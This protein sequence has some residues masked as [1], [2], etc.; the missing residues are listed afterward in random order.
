MSKLCYNCGVENNP[1][2]KKC[3]SCKKPLKEKKAV[4]KPL[5]LP[6]N[7]NLGKY[8]IR[9]LVT[10]TDMGA[11][12]LGENKDTGEILAIKELSPSRASS[13]EEKEYTV[14]KFVN[15]SVL[16]KQLNFISV[17]RVEEYFIANENHYMSMEF[18]EGLD[19]EGMVT[20]TGTPGLPQEQVVKWGMQICEVLDYLHKC[21]PQIIYR[22]LKPANIM[23]RNS[24]NSVVLIDFGIAFSFHEDLKGSPRTKIGT[25]GYMAPEQFHGK[26]SPA[27]DVF[28]LGATLYYALTGQVQQLFNYIPMTSI[29][30]EIS[31]ELDSIIRCSLQTSPAKR[32]ASAAEMKEALENLEK[33]KKKKEEELKKAIENLKPVESKVTKIQEVNP[34]IFTAIELRQEKDVDK[35]LDLMEK[36]AEFSDPVVG[37]TLITILLED[38]DLICCEEAAKILGRKKITEAIS[39]LIEVIDDEESDSDFVV[40]CIE[41]LGH[42][43]EEQSLK[44]LIKCLKSKDKV[45]RKSAASALKNT[46]SEKALKPLI[47]ARKKEGLFN[48]DVKKIIDSAIKSIKASSGIELPE[49]EDNENIFS[50]LMN[51]IK[52]LL[53]ARKKKKAKKTVATKKQ[54]NQIQ[55]KKKIKG[56]KARVKK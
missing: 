42:F 23:I 36:L 22:D 53:G 35:K 3:E 25:M 56:K 11:V 18:I 50:K 19:M 15:E 54:T 2:A 44:C 46:G 10:I 43:D 27:S 45:I 5:T 16:L 4:A 13:E 33:N 6:L 38:E 24:D 28:S 14:N 7:S 39:T 21:D 12:Y 49:E 32:Y 20:T 29:V 8:I 37:E 30:P 51:F 26:V 1:G 55:K 17:P 41:G 31:E 52:N 47:R 9:G 40:A 34:A 48:G